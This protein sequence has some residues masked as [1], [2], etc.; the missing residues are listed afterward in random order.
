MQTNIRFSISLLV[1]YVVILKRN[2]TRVCC[3]FNQLNKYYFYRLNLISPLHIIY[4]CQRGVHSPLVCLSKYVFVKIN[5][6]SVI[7]N[8][9]KTCLCESC[10]RALIATRSEVL[11]KILFFRIILVDFC[12]HTQIMC[13]FSHLNNVYVQF[14]PYYVHA[15]VILGLN[16]F[17]F[18]MFWQ[19][20]SILNTRMIIKRQDMVHFLILYSFL[21]CNFSCFFLL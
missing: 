20:N 18:S 10:I 13:L 2:V 19:S 15:Y 14:L 7:S 6:T 8:N 5:V 11:I 17:Y 1:S 4:R 12:N 9:R 21:F 16:Y 3:Y